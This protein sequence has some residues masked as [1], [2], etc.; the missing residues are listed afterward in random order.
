[1]QF[2]GSLGLSMNHDVPRRPGCPTLVTP[3]KKVADLDQAIPIALFLCEDSVSV[4]SSKVSFV[5]L[6][7]R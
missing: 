4:R 5:C 2:F 3:E 1:M 6:L 7:Q